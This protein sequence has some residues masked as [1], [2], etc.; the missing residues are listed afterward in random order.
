LRRLLGV[1]LLAY[2]ALAAGDPPRVKFLWPTR[3]TTDQMG[4]AWIVVV[5]RHPE[6]RQLALVAV[7]GD[8]V[9]RRSD[10]QLE[11]EKAPRVHRIEWRGALPAGELTIAALVFSSTNEVARATVPITVAQMRP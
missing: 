11:G 2:C 5:E 3:F 1:A 10:V 8:V 4:T 9:I 7:D 6:H